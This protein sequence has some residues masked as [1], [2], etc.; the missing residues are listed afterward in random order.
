[1]SQA[2]EVDEE[3]AAA[4]DSFTKWLEKHKLP[5]GLASQLA[6][7]TLSF[8]CPKDLKE[9]PPDELEEV[10]EE[11]KLTGGSKKQFLA[12]VVCSFP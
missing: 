3:V 5:E 10:C 12:A 2:P 8:S 11:L 1:M 6:G 7:D 9:C 4:I